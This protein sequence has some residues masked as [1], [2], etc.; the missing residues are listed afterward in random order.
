MIVPLVSALIELDPGE[1]VA[2]NYAMYLPDAWHAITGVDTLKRSEDV[3]ELSAWLSVVMAI[4]SIVVVSLYSCHLASFVLYATLQS[5]D[6]SVTVPARGTV[7]GPAWA[8]RHVLENSAGVTTFVNEFP[9][10]K[11][12]IDFIRSGRGVYVA[13]E[14]TAMFV[15]GC[16][17]SRSKIGTT[18]L[19]FSPGFPT[20][21]AS[22]INST[23]LD[24]ATTWM[25][26]HSDVLG[27]TIREFKNV[28]T[29]E[30][31]ITPQPVGLSNV[32]GLFVLYGSF[33]LAITA[34]SFVLPFVRDTVIP[35]AK[36]GF[37]WVVDRTR[38]L[39]TRVELPCTAVICAE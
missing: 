10:S 32:I 36:S 23:D 18:Q 12:T 20:G 26:V 15:G 1:T 11:T 39:F 2:T 37:Y 25:S 21:H 19:F 7:Y 3:T 8:E 34:S 4:A 24:H 22:I 5:E 17:A 16:S 30:C 29:G 38:V 9:P 14:I 35:R 28:Y 33:V 27:N 13:D 31:S 6:N